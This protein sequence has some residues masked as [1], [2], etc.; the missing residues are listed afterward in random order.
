N[1]T[2][3]GNKITSV[4]IALIAFPDPTISDIIGSALVLS[5]QYLQ[6]KSP[7]GIED[8][9]KQFNKINIKLKEMQL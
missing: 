4:G 8:V 6:R 1:K 2:N 9:Y 7:I 5:G 3:I